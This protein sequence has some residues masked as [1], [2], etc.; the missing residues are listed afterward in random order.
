MNLI[1]PAKGITMLKGIMNLISPATISYQH[2]FS[3]FSGERHHDVERH[4][5]SDF[6][7][8]HILSASFSSFIR[9]PSS[10][11]LVFSLISLVIPCKR[12]YCVVL[13]ILTFEDGDAL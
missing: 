2:R 13:V 9:R 11:E 10:A 5:E 7:S 4:H 12:G 1:S 3:D 8:D 6:S